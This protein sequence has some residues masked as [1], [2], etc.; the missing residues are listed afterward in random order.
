M[1]RRDPIIHAGSGIVII[2]DED[3]SRWVSVKDSTSQS[4]LWFN[5]LTVVLHHDRTVQVDFLICWLTAC[6]ENQ[7]N[8]PS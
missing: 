8:F 2:H 1:R 7:N 5:Q 6:H 4:Q 3:P